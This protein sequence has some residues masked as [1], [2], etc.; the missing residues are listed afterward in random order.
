[1]KT[2]SHDNSD[3]EKESRAGKWKIPACF[4]VL[5]DLS[6]KEREEFETVISEPITLSHSV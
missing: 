6:D 4:E 2:T 3:W 1:M 5:T